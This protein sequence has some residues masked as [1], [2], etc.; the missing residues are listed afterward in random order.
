MV[1]R[2]YFT[3]LDTYGAVYLLELKAELKKLSGSALLPVPSIDLQQ[4]PND[5][6]KK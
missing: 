1:I 4:R 5:E 3:Y 6:T 2:F